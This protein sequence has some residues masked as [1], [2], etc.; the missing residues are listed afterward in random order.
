M[1]RRI[2]GMAPRCQRRRRQP[3]PALANLLTIGRPPSPARGG[4]G[5]KW[6]SI[7]CRKAFVDGSLGSHTAAFLVPSTDAPN[8]SGLLVT[9]PEYR[10]RWT[11]G[12]T[13]AGLRPMVHATGAIAGMQPYDAIDDGLSRQSDRSGRR[14]PTRSGACWIRMCDWHSAAIGT[15]RRTLNGRHPRRRAEIR[16][17]KAGK[18]G[19][20]ECGTE[21]CAPQSRYYGQRIGVSIC[22]GKHSHGLVSSWQ[23]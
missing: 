18:R 19:V 9:A 8:D 1:S 7:G 5:E 2:S 15:C 16:C 6:P 4:R 22:T 17:S 21:E 23:P 3:S 13:S 14:P 10:C 11:S 12:A 20:A